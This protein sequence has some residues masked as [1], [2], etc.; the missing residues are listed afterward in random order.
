MKVTDPDWLAAWVV[1][2][3]DAADGSASWGPDCAP[4]FAPRAPWHFRAACHRDDDSPKRLIAER[5]GEYLHKRVLVALT[6]KVR[7][8]AVQETVENSQYCG[9]IASISYEQGITV[10]VPGGR[11]HELP[12]DLSMLEPASPGRYTLRPTGEVVTDPD[13]VTRWIVV[14]SPRGSSSGGEAMGPYRML[15]AGGAPLWD[16]TKP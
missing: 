13:Y 9:E 4:L 5:S 7:D 2:A 12:P 1:T 11:E 8:A 15:Q 3:S 14:E 10:A 16:D 6:I